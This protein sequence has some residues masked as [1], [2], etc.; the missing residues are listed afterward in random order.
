MLSEFFREIRQK[1]THGY[2]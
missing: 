2:Y 1:F